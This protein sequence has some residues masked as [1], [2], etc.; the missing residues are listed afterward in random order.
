MLMNRNSNIR[1]IFSRT[2]EQ[3]LKVRAK[4]GIAN[5]RNNVAKSYECHQ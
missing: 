5:F 3:E 4:H 1:M 2:I